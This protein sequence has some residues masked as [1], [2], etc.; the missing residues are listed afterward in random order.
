MSNQELEIPSGYTKMVCNRDYRLSSLSGN[1]VNFKANVPTLVHPFAYKEAIGIGAVP[2][3]DEPEPE[4]VEKIEEVRHPVHESVAEAAKLE[5]EA[6]LGA[7]ENAIVV[8]MKRGDNTDFRADGYPKANKV[9]EEMP[10]NVNRAT[11]TEIQQVY[12]DMR[13]D[14]NYADLM[15][16]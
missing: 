14:V 1:V 13:D 10:P 15:G 9:L 16:G 12:D 2:A 8:L 5:H 7:I 6:K 4:M 11:A 3:P